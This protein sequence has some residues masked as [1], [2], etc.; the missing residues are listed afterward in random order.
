MRISIDSRLLCPLRTEFGSEG[1]R[2]PTRSASATKKQRAEPH[3]FMLTSESFENEGAIPD[4]LARD[5]GASPQLS[6]RGAPA[7]TEH[8]VIIMDDPDA[9]SVV[10]H[11]FVHWVAR[12]PASASSLPEGASRGGWIGKPKT[13]SRPGTSTPY[14]GPRPP[15]GRHRYYI[16]VYALGR[17]F[18]ESDFK[19]LT[20]S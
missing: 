14:R 9:E 5:Y 16:K 4:R 8:F 6:W 13:L 3:G 19:N 15:S 11:T 17:S 1:K 7:G 12:V 18:V 2:G 20:Q 10:G